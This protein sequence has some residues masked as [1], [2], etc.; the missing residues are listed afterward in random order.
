[1]TA[2]RFQSASGLRLATA[3]TFVTAVLAG[4]VVRTVRLCVGSEASTG[5]SLPTEEL[6]PPGFDVLDREG[7]VLAMSVRTID[8]VLSPRSLWQA[9]TPRRIAAKLSA[10]LGGDPSPE[11]LLPR[12]VPDAVGGVITVDPSA[13]P[14]PLDAAR[15]RRVRDWLRGWNPRTG[16]QEAP[17]HGIALVPD[18]RGRIT[19]AWQPEV[20]LSAEE[21]A[22]HGGAGGAPQPL[23]WSR[24][25]ADGLGACL[26]GE[27]A[28][29]TDRTD[30][31]RLA[32]QRRAI[33]RALMPC[34][35]T[36]ALA[37]LPAEKAESLERVLDAEGVASHQMHLRYRSD[38]RYPVRTRNPDAF[39]ILGGWRYPSAR[40]AVDAALAAAGRSVADLA[41]PALRAQVVARARRY[42]DEKRPATGIEALCA[43]VLESELASFVQPAPAR[44]VYRVDRAVHHR[45]RRYFRAEQ[46]ESE[47]PRVWT[48]L[49]AELS[50]RLRAELER[51]LEEHDAAL[52]MGIV[53]DLERGDVLAADGTAIVPLSEFLPTWHLFTPGSTFKVLTMA[54]ALDEGVVRPTDEFPTHGGEF[55]LSGRGYRVIHEAEGAPTEPYI[56]AS[57]GL[58][59]SVNAVLVQIGLRL[60][61][62]VF[63][64]RLA[65]LGYG[66]LP[67]TGIGVE[68]AGRLPGLPWSRNFTHASISFGHEITT[69]LWQ[70]ATALAAVLRG[71]VVRPLRLIDAIE[72]GGER[73][74]VPPKEERRVF[75]PRT[76]A[77]VRAM[78]RR[79]A[80][81]GTGRLVQQRIEKE[82]WPLWIASKTGTAQKTPSEL[83]LHRELRLQQENA[84]RARRGEPPVP[85]SSLRGLGPLGHRAC[86]TS[87]ICLVGHV[88]GETREVM[89]L[90]VVEEPR[91]GGRFGSR[92]AGPA[93]LAVLAEA[94]G[95]APPCGAQRIPPPVAGGFLAAPGDERSFEDIPWAEEV[96]LPDEFD[97][98]RPEAWGRE[99][100][101]T[102]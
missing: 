37:G 41:D 85:L 93:A 17:L 76:C 9:H 96:D 61:D 18:E 90:V 24:R 53:I 14:R 57:L 43:R 79:G 8:L 45:P 30:D 55:R 77:E 27:E 35:E 95:V 52:A 12:L 100:P 1:M 29:R 69:S 58:A 16:E 64:D 13:L 5:T 72:W 25:I 34:G 59:R 44:Y 46:P 67:G 38:R 20:L 84:E 86:Y 88:E 33:W 11:A 47:A 73:V 42:C 63:H 23:T 92:V 68:R 66:A 101:A 102:W 91:R 54:C 75:S 80:L 19:L 94:L 78:M 32:E 56:S 71:G 2:A 39:A 21:R 98:S 97:L 36:V 60:D 51:T 70:H 3:F 81:E 22:L 10:A 31:A 48:T 15:V 99:V 26:F 4:I 6:P 83:C 49:D 28:A 87:S 65:R 89:V 82:G 40:Q 62:R 50:L 74:E 7:R